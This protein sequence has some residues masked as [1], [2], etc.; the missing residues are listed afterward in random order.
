MSFFNKNSKR[1]AFT[2]MEVALALLI[3][4]ILTITLLPVMKSKLSKSDE[5]YYYMAYKTVE[6][7]GGQIVALGEGDTTA[8]A[9]DSTKIA[10]SKVQKNDFFNKSNKNVSTP[11]YKVSMFFKSLGEK[12]VYSEQFV[13]KKLFPKVYAEVVN[14]VPIFTQDEYDEQSLQFRFCSGQNL[15]DTNSK[16]K[17]LFKY[18]CDIKGEN[19]IVQ[20]KCLEN[21][22]RC[23]DS[24]YLNLNDLKS[25][26]PNYK[27]VQKYKKTVSSK[28]WIK[29][30]V[31]EQGNKI[32]P[33]CVEQWSV[34][35]VTESVVT[36]C[37]PGTVES[38]KKTSTTT[39]CDKVNSYKEELKCHTLT[40]LDFEDELP[41]GEKEDECALLKNNSDE[42]NETIQ[43]FFTRSFH[44]TVPSG[45]DLKEL[46]NAMLVPYTASQFC[47]SFVSRYCNG[48]ESGVN[49][50][51]SFENSTCSVG[52]IASG[53]AGIIQEEDE[54]IRPD[55]DDICNPSH[56][57]YNMYNAGGKKSLQCTC[58][59][60]M[61]LSENNSRVCCPKPPT[62]QLAYARSDNT[63]IN[64]STNY[65]PN[66]GGY[67][68][69]KN[70]NYTGENDC[71]CESGYKSIGSG[72]N[73]TCVLDHCAKGSHFDSVN[74]VCVPDIPILK[75]ESLCNKINKYWNTSSSNC[76]AFSDDT[77]KTSVFNAATG[78]DGIYL[79][80]KAK[81]GGF[82]NIT[83][84]I[85]FANGQKL[86]ILGNKMASIPGL[87]FN[88]TNIVS[89]Q[90]ICKD[91]T[92]L[93]TGSP[94][95]TNAT[96]R[97]DNNEYLC[98]GEK[99][100]FTLVAGLDKL[101]D[102]RNCCSSTDVNDLIT[103]TPEHDN[104]A[105]A[106]NGFTVFVDAN[107]K[108]GSST[109]WEDVFPFYVS[110]N[111]RVYPGY[112][113]N[114]LKTTKPAGASTSLY[115]AGNSSIMLPTEVYYYNTDPNE[116]KRRKVIAYSN[117]SYAKAA[118]EAKWVNQNTPYCLNLGDKYPVSSG[119]NP[120][121]THKCFI[122]VRNKA[123]IF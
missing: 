19:C 96:C 20:A 51:V 26:D 22:T 55:V 59:T 74:K 73:M 86:W 89:G 76:S 17:D 40:S 68:C 61:Y 16:Q 60:D 116:E 6:K 2:L 111:G 8:S 41:E 105:F 13:M 85:V 38:P 102:A 45:Q 82:S 109:L 62:N 117:V 123:R 97:M 1:K 21:N 101:G 78:T 66:L 58:L 37:S 27:F 113:L 88:P 122:N 100:C 14:I 72:P 108:K 95:T 3:V 70:S 29:C 69:P 30:P 52:E 71:K 7:L 57:Y 112:P 115:L 9:N 12:F 81:V 15:C 77:Y 11:G 35:S 39:I 93:D 92:G 24:K 5:Y 25:C 31:D 48:A 63:C 33:K 43:E 118:C 36:S 91:V 120:C 99:H 104:R 67:C 42:I 44:C 98:K 110:S 114:A 83:P 87:S 47:S 121:N 28:N 54:Y 80:I 90:N 4:A 49:V 64:C 23:C 34:P 79:S 46:Y 65:N 94:K 106:I 119:N 18:E 56:G 107:G 103:T 53:N 32:D 75:A 84:D 50:T 10:N